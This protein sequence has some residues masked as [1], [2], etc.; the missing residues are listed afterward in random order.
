MGKA[1]IREYRT[2]A[3]RT[4][5]KPSIELV[6]LMEEEGQGFCLACGEVQDGVESDA[7]RYTCECCGEAKVYGAGEL[8][9]MGLIF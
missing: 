5:Y 4:Q 6:M 8:A 2:K 7:T 1:T 3:G 9:L